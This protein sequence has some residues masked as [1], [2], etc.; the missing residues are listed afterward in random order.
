M[1]G[2]ASD[3][4]AAELRRCYVARAKQVHPDRSRAASAHH[5]MALAAHAW[6]VL[7]DPARRAAFD[8]ERTLRRTMPWVAELR[9][10]RANQEL[11]EGPVAESRFL[12]EHERRPLRSALLFAFLALCLALLLFGAASARLAPSLTTPV[13]SI[14]QK[15]K[16]EKRGAT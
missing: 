4:S 14:R 13:G 2:A 11:F 1:L 8:E 7:R 5:D 15:E 6:Q 12:R 9:W 3:A 16:D 10:A